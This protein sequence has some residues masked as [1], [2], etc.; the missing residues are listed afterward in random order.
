MTH[1]P[2]KH[3]WLQKLQNTPLPDQQRSTHISAVDQQ[4][5][6]PKVSL[7]AYIF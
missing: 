6:K 4:C 1:Q 7:H 3:I 5:T 2:I